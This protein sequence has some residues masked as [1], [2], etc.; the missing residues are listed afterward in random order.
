MKNFILVQEVFNQSNQEIPQLHGPN[1]C[2]Y[3][4]EKSKDKQIK[5]PR[6]FKSIQ[7]YEFSV[8]KDEKL[9][10][11]SVLRNTL[12]RP[13]KEKTFI[14]TLFFLLNEEYDDLINYKFL[15]ASTCPELP[16]FIYTMYVRLK[17]GMLVQFNITYSKESKKHTLAMEDFSFPRH[18]FETKKYI[19]MYY[20]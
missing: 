13:M 5:I 6:V 3:F 11:L 8:E 10:H 9:D 12:S 2:D 18:A 14:R 19:Y 7:T 17:S 1:F 15:Y 4:L 20:Q 16:D